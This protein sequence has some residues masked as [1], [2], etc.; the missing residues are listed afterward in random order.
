MIGFEKLLDEAQ[1]DVIMAHNIDTLLPA[2]RV[3]LRRKALL[4]FDS[5]EFHSDMG[6]SQDDMQRRLIE[7]IERRCLLECCLITTSSRRVARALEQQYG[8]TV[9]LPLYNTPPRVEMLNVPKVDGFGLYWRNSVIGLGQRGLAD[10]IQALAHLPREIS[11]HVQGRTAAD[12][13]REVAGLADRLGVGDRIIYH[14]PYRPERAVE[15]AARFHV[16]L[17]LERAGIKNHELT[18]SNKMFDYHMAGLPVVV[19]DLPALHDVIARSE[20]GL[21]FRPGD[22]NDLVGVIRR[23]HASRS[24]YVQLSENAR[25]F[26]LSEGNLEADMARFRTG[27]SEVLKRRQSDVQEG[28]RPERTSLALH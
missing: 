24:L 28:C 5:M 21:L 17:C 8:V 15:E 10:A 14:P 1:P 11:L 9:T 6:D 12:G 20:G 3:A 27:F 2:Y 23:I 26:A 13:G 25:A 19:S 22:V 4:V 18:V 16:G 7:R